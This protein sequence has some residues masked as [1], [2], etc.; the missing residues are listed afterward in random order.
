MLLEGR[1]RARYSSTAQRGVATSVV[2]ALCPLDGVDPLPAPIDF[3]LPPRALLLLEPFQS[4]ISLIVQLLLLGLSLLLD[5]VN[6]FLLHCVHL[7]LYSI[8]CLFSLLFE[9]LNLCLLLFI[10]RFDHFQHHIIATFDFLEL[11]KFEAGYFL[12]DSFHLRLHMQY[13]DGRQCL[14]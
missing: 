3:P 1:T 7:C 14:D 13:Q 12:V 2:R 4:G 9:G 10:G 8:L 6:L 11:F 5:V